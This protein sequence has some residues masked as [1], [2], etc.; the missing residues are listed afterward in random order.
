MP[1]RTALLLA[2][3]LPL[4]LTALADGGGRA[5]FT[6]MGMN[7]A[8]L[9]GAA[10]YCGSRGGQ[11]L[12]D[13]YAR[14]LPHFD[15]SPTDII[16]V[17]VVVEERRRQA[18]EQS[19]ATFANRPC[20]AQTRDKMQQSLQE[21]ENAWY[22]VVR[23]DTGVDLR[24]AAPVPVATATTPRSTPT[25]G[26]CTKGAAVSVLYGGQ[27]YPAKVLDGPDHMG[28]C[29]VSYDGYGSNWDDWVNATR[30]RPAA[31]TQSSPGRTAQAAPASTTPP[32]ATS[33]S[34]AI[35]TGK[36]S[37]YTFDNGQLNY[38]YTDVV[39]QPGGGYA[40]GNDSGSYTLSDGGAMR[41]TGTMANATGKFSMKNGGKPQI[42]LVFNGDARASMSCPKGR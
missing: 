5:K 35:P 33:G 24:S 31:G 22:R 26:L 20:P 3:G 36:Y 2:V 37:C 30:M 19:A 39:I 8:P 40:V 41:F 12:L 32:P 21:M 25:S 6:E 38:T 18:R 34:S 4:S 17:L 29:L 23:N 10:D 7:I 13:A 16:A 15:L 42:D 11:T 9:I 27:W 28:T 1:K 14:G